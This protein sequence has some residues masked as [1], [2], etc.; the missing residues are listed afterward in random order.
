MEVPLP[1][2]PG[3][4]KPQTQNSL[5]VIGVSQYRMCSLEHHC[6]TGFLGKPARTQEQRLHHLPKRQG[7]P[8]LSQLLIVKVFKGNVSSP[9][10]VFQ[11]NLNCRIFQCVIQ[12]EP[13][14]LP[15]SIGKKN[16]S[17]TCPGAVISNWIPVSQLLLLKIKDVYAHRVAVLLIKQILKV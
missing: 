12:R 13:P 17:N 16:D 5:V 6:S 2:I 14:F 4:R 9:N 1:T 15:S 3:G 11:P 7:K 8:L 10:S